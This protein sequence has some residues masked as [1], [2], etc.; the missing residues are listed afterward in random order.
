[1]NYIIYPKEQKKVIYPWQINHTLCVK[2]KSNTIF[3][4]LSIK[5]KSTLKQNVHSFDVGQFILIVNIIRSYPT[6]ERGCRTRLFLQTAHK[7][8]RLQLNVS[9]LLRDMG[10]NSSANLCTFG[11]TTS[12]THHC[13]LVSAREQ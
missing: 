9:D 6:Q 1:M 13:S 12:D 8:A 11:S 4:F 2:S 5:G 3:P 7:G 10:R